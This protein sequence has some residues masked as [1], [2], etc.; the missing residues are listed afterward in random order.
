MRLPLFKPWRA[1]EQFDDLS[2]SECQRH[3]ADAFINYPWLG[4]IP[5]IL[6]LFTLLAWPTTWAI[7]A[8]LGV[9][10]KWIP[11]ARSAEWV[12]I[13]LIVTTVLATAGV[14]WVTRDLAIWLG[15][16]RSLL[17]GCCP[18]CRQ[19]LAGVPLHTAG[20]NNDPS[21]QWVR[22]PECGKKVML[23]EHGITPRD[24]VPWELRR[25]DPNLAKRRDGAAW[26]GRQ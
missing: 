1:F 7:L 23:L 5:I 21:L 14:Y 19:S 3:V 13:Q 15:L 16:R 4:R 10:P 22:C 17:R 9:I 2:D 12:G 8:G 24:L 6:S 20:I 25:P 11:V 26:K 18:K